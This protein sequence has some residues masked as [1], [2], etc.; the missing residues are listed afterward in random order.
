MTR[1]FLSVAPLALILSAVLF[2]SC[3][4][5]AERPSYV[6]NQQAMQRMEKGEYTE[7]I[8]LLQRALEIQPQQDVL[9]YNLGQAYLRAGE[10]LIREYRYAEASQMLETGKQYDGQEARFWLFNGLAL[11]KANDYLYAESEL[12]EAWSMTG[13]E[14]QV[15]TLLGRLYYHTDRM[16][17]A[18]DAWERVLILSPQDQVVTEQLERLRRELA[19]EQE[20]GKEYGGHFIINY[21]GEVPPSLGNDVLEVLEDAY[22]WVSGQ[23]G[24]Y[25]QRRIPVILYA[26]T[27]FSNLTNSPDW[28]AGV[29]DGKIRLP[30]G[31]ISQVDSR[32]RGLL[33]HEFMHVV[34]R[35]LAGNNVPLWLNEGLAEVAS[36]EHLSPNMT[37][38][39][40]AR[41]SG[42]L[43]TWPELESSARQF[44]AARAGLAYLQSYD[45]VRFLL[46]EYGW[47]Q[48][49]E[50]LDALG[51]GATISAAIDR[52]LGF[53]AVD[54]ATLQLRWS[55]ERS[56]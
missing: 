26:N 4:A 22:D 51:S 24:H 20:M 5:A 18:V 9:R 2:F 46:D 42:T 41:E 48:M 19:V 27:D 55:E 8:R 32:V 52:A 40:Q 37:L 15:L 3:A 44:S 47:F 11:L 29:Y 49:R 53:Y 33:F 12:H 6:L 56:P 28:A 7:A 45:F 39:E 10:Q 38:L 21:D 23:L 13:D 43:F 31:G 1:S 50:L 35:E 14:V 25:P 16:R 34:V 17:E 54:Y 30:A 36:A